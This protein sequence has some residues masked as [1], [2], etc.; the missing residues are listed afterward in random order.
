M[1]IRGQIIKEGKARGIAIVSEEP[2]SLLGGIDAKTGKISEPGHPLK[3][4]PVSGRVLV[5]SHGKGSTVGSYVLYQLA[6]AKKA[7]AG[8]INRQAEPIVAV[9]AILAELPMVHRLDQDPLELIESGDLV[10]ID[11]E[12]VTVEKR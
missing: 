3:G 6:R 10:I 8:I 11:G 5:F 9:G 12:T 1:K 4:E 7:P 2:I